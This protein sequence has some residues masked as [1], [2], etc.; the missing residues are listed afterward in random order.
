MKTIRLCICLCFCFNTLFAQQEELEYGFLLPQFESGFVVFKN[1][2]RSSASL[3]YS[4]LK[5]AMMFMDKENVIL[6][7]A[8]PL[9]I[10]VVI[11]GER[12]FFPVSSKGTFYEEIKTGNGFF[13]VNY[14]A[15]MA[16]Q[17]KEAAYGGYSQ[18]SAST[19][20]G[21][22]E[23]NSSIRVKLKSSE[24]FSMKT[25]NSYFIKSGD[26]YKRIFSAK[27]L[28]KL[29][30]GQTSKI[31]EFA[32]EQSID[33]SKPDDIAKIVEYAFNLTNN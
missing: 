12:R 21:S 10:L 14:K 7:F 29:F 22:F 18:T 4:M 32:K 15:F 2:M 27:T 8:D 5:Q 25:E 19:S 26:K 3:N 23:N 16:S 1:G 13:Y 20:L 33:F 11:I 6:E 31:E 24:K 30:K 17:G 28:G 9:S